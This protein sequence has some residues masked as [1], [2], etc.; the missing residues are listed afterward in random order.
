M[1]EVTVANNLSALKKW[2][3]PTLKKFNKMDFVK[4]GPGSGANE[5]SSYSA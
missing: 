3:E 1:K 5:N 4:G 2:E